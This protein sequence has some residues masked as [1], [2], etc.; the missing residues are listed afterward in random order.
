MKY[1]YLQITN[2]LF[3][4]CKNLA[5]L[6]SHFDEISQFNINKILDAKY[7]KSFLLETVISDLFELPNLK[8]NLE[9]LKIKCNKNRNIKKYLKN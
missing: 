2:Q 5:E 9:E 8:T 7:A 6:W 3:T 4:V 1:F